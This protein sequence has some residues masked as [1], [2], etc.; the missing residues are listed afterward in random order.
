MNIYGHEVELTA[1]ADDDGVVTDVLVLARTVRFS[2]DGR[3][4]DALFTSVTR[5]STY[6]LQM[7]MLHAAQG[8]LGMAYDDDEDEQ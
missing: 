3:A 6:M 1:L 8:C 4:E 2:D 7:G 5:S